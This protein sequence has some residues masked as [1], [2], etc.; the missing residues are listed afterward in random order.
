[1]RFHVPQFIE[2]EDK[3]FGPLTFKQFAYMGGAVGLAYLVYRLLPAFLGYPLALISI[4][5]GAA[6]AFYKINNRPFIA[7]LEAG[8]SYLF[9]SK[10]YIWKKLPKDPLESSSASTSYPA[11]QGPG[12]PTLGSNKLGSKAWNIDVSK[13]DRNES[14]G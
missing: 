13:G 2:V 9:E 3:I 1:M 11:R 6:L 5:L 12:V 8:F 10:L 14:S 4:G 7:L